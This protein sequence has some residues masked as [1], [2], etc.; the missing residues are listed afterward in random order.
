MP[1]WLRRRD[2]ESSEEPLLILGLALVIALALATFL[3][4]VSRALGGPGPHLNAWKATCYGVGPACCHPGCHG[5][6]GS[7]PSRFRDGRSLPPSWLPVYRQWRGEHTACRG[8]QPQHP[9]WSVVPP[10]HRI[11]A[12]LGPHAAVRRTLP[13]CLQTPGGRRARG[14]LLVKAGR[15]MA[16]QKGGSS[17]WERTGWALCGCQSSS[18]S[19]L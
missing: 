5:L 14:R 17:K 1:D 15:T 13:R 3:L 8:P 18:S 11:G 6:A 7:S 2:Q 10:V 4:L 9:G 12:G 16:C 19:L